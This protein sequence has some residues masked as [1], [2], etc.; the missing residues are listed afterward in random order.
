[1]SLAPEWRIGDLVLTEAPF[2]VRFGTDYG[3]PENVTELLLSMLDGDIEVSPRTGNRTLSLPVLIEDADL[4]ALADAEALLLAEC[5]KA[6]NEVYVDPGD[7]FAE[8]LIFDVFRGQVTFERDDNFEVAG[9]R[10]YTVTFRALPFARSVDEITL[11]PTPTNIGTARQRSYS[12]TAEGSAR[13]EAA[14]HVS[15]SASGLGASTL[16]YTRPGAAGAIP[17]RQHRSGGGATTADAALVSGTRDSD[18]TTAFEA[19]VP[20]T[21]VPD[22]DYL[23]FARLACS[24]SS[25]NSTLTVTVGTDLAGYTPRSS[26]SWDVAATGLETAYRWFQIS[27]VFSLPTTLIASEPDADVIVLIADAASGLTVR[28]D[29]AI[30]FEVGTGALTWVNTGPML[31]SIVDPPPD[32]KHVWVDPATVARPYRRLLR[33][34]ESDQ[35]DAFAAEANAWASHVLE[36]GTN[37]ALVVAEGDTSAALEVTFSPRWHTHAGS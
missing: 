26:R 5:D 33:G 31:S 12:F 30:L 11:T 6:R 18:I 7:G 1:M 35:T 21:E 34:A 24:S 36:P 20:K 13:T 8:P 9:A 25:G 22:G 28:L 2:M 27:S 14:L 32:G 19:T 4:A 17:L 10:Q 23:L 3:T 29:E 37:T 15:G 16:V